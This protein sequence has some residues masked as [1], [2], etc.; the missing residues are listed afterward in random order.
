MTLPARFFFHSAR[1]VLFWFALAV[2]VPVVG[3][4][5]Y[6]GLEGR[7]AALANAKVEASRL[8]A[9]V[10][11]QHRSLAE[12]VRTLMMLTAADEEVTFGDRP[13]CEYRLGDIVRRSSLVTGLAR[14]RADGQVT[15]STMHTDKA[16]TPVEAA[17][18]YAATDAGAFASGPGALQGR[19]G[20]ALVP[21]ALPLAAVDDDAV[22]LYL[23]AQVNL[24]WLQD[25]LGRLEAPADALV[26]VTGPDGTILATAPPRGDLIGSRLPVDDDA[27]LAA[28]V[29]NGQSRLVAVRDF[30]GG[31]RVAVG[32]D[33]HRVLAEADAAF[34]RS[35]G[36]LMLVAVL[37]M[38]LAGVMGERL[39]VTPLRRLT[40]AA[41]AMADGNLTSRFGPTG[42][43]LLGEI[44][45]LAATFDAMADGLQ[46]R[47]AELDAARERL[48]TVIDSALDGI[49]TVDAAGL[50]R[51]ANPAA[52][53]M[54]G[55]SAGRLEGQHALALVQQSPRLRRLARLAAAGRAGRGLVLEVTARRADGSTLPVRVSLARYG[56]G[57]ERRFVAV[58]HDVSAQKQ[59]EAEMCAAREEAE[60]ANQAKSAFLATM[61]HELRTPLNAILGFSE[62][63]RDRLLGPD[64][65]ARVYPT[66]AGHI[67]EA[68]S[69]LL[70][71]I[72]DI[73]DLSKIE[74]GRMTLAP[75][76][77]DLR[78]MADDAVRLVRGLADERGVRLET[79][80][81]PDLPALMVD[82]RA[83][84]QMLVNLL[85][86]AVRF[87]EPGGRVTI[88]GRAVS[89]TAVAV[90]VRDT[91]IGMTPDEMR[92]ALEP[93][94]QADNPLQS[95]T[96]GTGLGLPLVKALTELH[97]GRFRLASVKGRGT[98]VTLIL[99]AAASTRAGAAAPAA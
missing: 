8:A 97:G 54:L 48:R 1:G 83:G 65:D 2:L 94:G 95:E 67:H 57:E 90:M 87:T 50:V 22:P 24:A 60:R 66:Y 80:L 74:A 10:A 44:G 52:A 5:A 47:E 93:F 35:M 21:F 26:F 15:C 20:R 71:L 85:S 86:N 27:A 91:G 17:A 61:S 18:L 88:E 31:I 23:V 16:L 76:V 64:A 13:T 84:R 49:L 70:G 28:L 39:I 99:T 81:S 34:A 69:H 33:R 55:Y 30:E 6:N 19:G 37:G 79:A 12:G 73:L 32:F 72:N 82:P 53:Q 75:A 11:E 56:E 36:V 59:A 43:P 3:L 63:I 58:V 4:G 9:A 25:R 29:D 7:R 62:V 51:G 98:T 14:A 77:Q 92:K 68:G 41:G 42:R 96:R 78:G 38:V 46:R 45:D 89:P 40:V